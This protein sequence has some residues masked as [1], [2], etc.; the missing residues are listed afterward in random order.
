MI[1]PKLKAPSAEGQEGQM[2]LLSGT[3]Q[4]KGL[5]VLPMRS[6]IFLVGN[7]SEEIHFLVELQV[8]AGGPAG[9]SDDGVTTVVACNLSL[10]R[11]GFLFSP[12]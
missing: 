2:H 7:I 1:F 9:I 6:E 12:I 5:L 3:S 11:K 10:K 4:I 8:I